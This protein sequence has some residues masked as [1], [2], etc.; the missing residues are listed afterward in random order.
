[1]ALS[2]TQ[3]AAVL[4]LHN[5]YRCLHDA[6]ALTWSSAMATSAQAWA[7]KG[8][9]EHSDSYN[10]APPAGPAG[11]NLAWGF[12]DF[13][14]AID[15][16]YDE[17]DL[18]PEGS[19]DFR[20]GAGH[21]TA[22]VWKGATEIGCGDN[23]AKAPSSVLYVC[24]YKG[25]DTKDSTT[26]NTLGAFAENVLP[27][28]TK[29]FDECAEKVRMAMLPIARTQEWLIRVTPP[30]DIV[31]K[32]PPK[33]EEPTQQL[34]P[35]VRL[36]HVCGDTSEQPSACVG[37]NQLL[38]YRLLTFDPSCAGDGTNA[39]HVPEETC[40]AL[41]H[42]CCRFCHVLPSVTTECP[43]GEKGIAIYWDSAWENETALQPPAKVPSPPV[44]P[45]LIRIKAAGPGRV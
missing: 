17:V 39:T 13:D 5:T 32:P 14:S 11:E 24:R 35:P 25:S 19:N 28:N 7:D 22:M 42:L 1:M 10:L 21:F 2:A 18:W 6:P 9:F 41:N 45:D 34:L 20:S 26:P 27:R 38:D 33:E 15:A 29:T 16:W 3:V 23:S 44:K 43:P 36:S 30:A 40:N 37:V 12:T 8:V 4:A 31:I